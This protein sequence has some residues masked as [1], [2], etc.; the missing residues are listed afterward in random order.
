MPAPAPG[1][2]GAAQA[3]APAGCDPA[4]GPGGASGDVRPGKFEPTRDGM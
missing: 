3:A 4:V 1:R 2:R